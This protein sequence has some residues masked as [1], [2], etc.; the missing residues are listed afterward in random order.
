MENRTCVL[1]LGPPNASYHSAVAA[2]APAANILDQTGGHRR[3]VYVVGGISR[4]TR[5][6]NGFAC[7]A[8]GRT[9]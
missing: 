4:N 9:N 2:A 6:E 3:T 8:C 5:T 7:A 1:A